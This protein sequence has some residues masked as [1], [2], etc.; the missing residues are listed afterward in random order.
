M[1]ADNVH[2]GTPTLQVADPRGLVVRTMQF[3]RRQSADSADVRVTHQRFDAAGRPVASR[4][5]YLFDLARTDASV[6]AN[7]SQVFSLSG[8]PLASDS[9]DAGWR[10]ALLGAAAQIIER[11]DGRG[12]HSSTEYDEL[13]RPTAVRERGL[14]VAEHVLERFSYAGVDDDAALRNLCGQLVRKDDP[15]GTLHLVDLGLGGARLKQTRHFLRDT[16]APD[17]P[18]ATVEQ[19]ALLEPGEGASTLQDYAPSGELLHQIDAFGNRQSFAYTVAGELKNTRLTLASAGQVEKLLVNNIEY[20]PSDQIETETA[21][22][23][24]IT[25]HRYDPANGRLTQLSAHKADGQPLQDLNYRYDAVGN[26][27]SIE[28]AAQAIRYFSN[29]RIEP[30]KTYSYDTLDQLIHATGWEAKAGRNGPAL[31]DVYP[32]PL[33]P[34]QLANY[35]QTYYYDAG[36]N[37]LDLVHVG[38]QAHGRTLSRARYSNRCLPERDGRP[39]TEAEL[40]AGFDAN[41]NLRELQAG[42]SLSWDLRNQLCAVYPIERDDGANDC[43]TNI[44]DGSGQR[45]RKIRTNQTNARTLISEVRYLPGIEIRSHGT[46]EILH[47]INASAGSNTVQVLHWVAKPPDEILNDQVRYNLNDHLKS[48]TLELDQNADLISQEWYYPFGDTAC[49]AARSATEAKY[50]TI[51]YSGKERDATGLYYYGF[52]Y[53]AP[54][55][56]RWINPDPAG[57]I[58][59]LNFFRMVRNNPIA[60][61]DFDGLSPEGDLAREIIHTTDFGSVYWDDPKKAMSDILDSLLDQNYAPEI[62]ELAVQ[63]ARQHFDAKKELAAEQIKKFSEKPIHL[64]Q[65]NIT[66]P[67]SKYDIKK[68]I[69]FYTTTHGSEMINNAMRNKKEIY[70]NESEVM[71]ELK[72]RHDIS[73]FE[74]KSGT[75]L[76]QDIKASAATFRLDDAD[77]VSYQLYHQ[78]NPSSRIYYR[79]GRLTKS[80]L[81]GYKTAKDNSSVLHSLSFLSAALDQSVTDDFRSTKESGLFIITGF[82]AASMNGGLS[83]IKGSVFSPHADFKVTKIDEQANVIHLKELRGYEGHRIPLPH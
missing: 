33:D 38:T 12:S 11:W 45:V 71:R 41:G 25:R 14:G 54:W 9:V 8:V 43:Q 70:I 47:V 56:Q 3:H 21:G 55:L 44:Y 32:L 51:R 72:E 57:A 78:S 31:S 19:D 74:G 34:N 2:R 75:Q 42:Q 67:K 13:L 82:S 50:K 18:T 83:V 28:D 48:S 49:Y 65:K 37:L 7:L 36:G 80:A 16:H 1:P 63:R 53:Y 60:L 10:V 58:D 4:D 39:P 26:V 22:N 29:Q 77:K 52:R 68:F 81:E 24:V 73:N 15:A 69:N 62:I 46:G 30:I 66:R 40:L 61:Y 76:K 64:P 5:P 17:W 20:N 59:G 79:A 23:G 27:L 35:S 6:P